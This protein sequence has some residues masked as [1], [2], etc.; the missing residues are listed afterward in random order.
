[1][2]FCSFQSEY[3]CQLIN[4]SMFFFEYLCQLI[5]PSMF[6][7]ERWQKTFVT[8]P[9]IHFNKWVE[10][11]RDL[12]MASQ[13]KFWQVASTGPIAN[14]ALNRLNPQYHRWGAAS[15][16]PDVALLTWTRHAGGSRSELEFVYSSRKRYTNLLP[17]CHCATVVVLS[18]L[19]VA[20][21]TCGSWWN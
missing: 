20:G 19:A 16:L 14:V 13:F 17:L 2:R 10:A 9:M 3:L 21:Q 7:F 1:M 6:F 4:P 15:S 8:N 18:S 11:A 5:N 12:L